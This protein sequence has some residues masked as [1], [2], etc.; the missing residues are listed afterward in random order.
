MVDWG[1]DTTSQG[2]GW[3]DSGNY[4]ANGREIS[5][6][7]ELAV[8]EGMLLA[9]HRYD[10]TGTY[11]A[12][13]EM[14]NPT[15]GVG[16]ANTIASTTVDVID[17]T[18][19]AAELVSPQAAVDPVV[20]FPVDFG[21]TNLE[22][23]G[24]AGLTAG[25]VRASI[26]VPEG[27]VVVS[28]DSRCVNANPI[29]CDLGDLAP[30]QSTTIA[31]VASIPLDAA[32]SE[33]GYLFTVELTDAG[34]NAQERNFH[35][36]SVNIAD[37]DADGVI[38]VDDAFADNP[39][40]SADSDGD[41]LAD[42]W[43]SDHGLDPFAADDPL[44]D[45]DGDGF[46]LLDEF[47][48][49]SFPNLAERQV[50]L[51]GQA[52]GVNNALDDRFGVAVAGG[53]LNQDGYAD[54]VIGAPLASATGNVYIQYG[55]EG[56]AV[57]AFQ[58]LNPQGSISQYGR[59]LAVGDWDDNGYPDV[60][61]SNSQG[62]YV[63]YNN[64]EIL[65]LHDDS[66]PGFLT[67]PMG[68]ALL[69]ADL[70]GDGT[71]DLIS[72]SIAG[73]TSVVYVYASSRGGFEANEPKILHESEHMGNSLTAG[74]IDGDGIP[75]L[76]VGSQGGPANDV[77]VYLG[78]DNDWGTR[79]GG[80]RSFTLQAP[81]GQSR[82]GYRVVSGA[83]VGGDG[84]DDVVVGD[85]GGAGAIHFY[86]SADNWIPPFGSVVAVTPSQ[87]INGLASGDQFGVALALGHLDTDP[88]AD[89]AVGGN[90]AGD[91]D[92]GQVRLLRGAPGGFQA[93]DQVEDG[94]TVFDM[95]GYS[96][97]I[98]GD[99]DGN[100]FND[101]VAGAPD[102]VANGRPSPDGGYVQVFYH[103]FV[104]VNPAEDPDGDGVADPLDNC[105]AVPNT[106]QSDIDDD[107]LG[108]VC[109]PDIDG[110]GTDNE[111]DSCPLDAGGDHSDFDNDGQGNV[112]DDDD[113]NDGTPDVDDPF[114]LDDRYVADSDADGMPDAFESANGLDPNDPTDAQGDLDSDGR[115][116]LEEFESLFWG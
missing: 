51:P 63:H 67:G 68:S 48:N 45:I 58:E 86:D 81:P 8:N 61:I 77:F 94:A 90:R 25:N 105:P 46:S 80:V 20:P 65:D 49:G 22:P 107:G 2:S 72:S 5:P 47:T 108:D 93:N 52:I 13:F 53:D 92:Q 12:S 87:T 115:S 44:A 27:V 110:D 23:D 15:N 75:D 31:L 106:N 3:A 83:D 9:S 71:D 35:V 103:G 79:V 99:I 59:A 85:Y 21:I 96:V 89:L 28:V 33:Q 100:G 114:P 39:D 66:H 7:I 10:S 101:V 88:Y 14:A 70:D 6:Q 56:G 26:E 24:W 50:A 64:G 74:D 97:A 73:S 42:R 38:D 11:Q 82:Y 98:P 1:D 41:G 19:V 18:A 43:E 37:A 84:V 76:L 78:R 34:P 104:A 116:N 36:A 95:L 29:D 57:P 111:L 54:I 91:Q 16:L 17:A 4:D 60:A 102:I 113:D 40:Y 69:S 32:R 62:I 109:D 30:A 112:C 55:A